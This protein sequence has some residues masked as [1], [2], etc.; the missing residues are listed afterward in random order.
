MAWSGPSGVGRTLL[1]AL[2][3]LSPGLALAG[4]PLL[5]E[6]QARGSVERRFD[7]TVMRARDVHVNMLALRTEANHRLELAL[8]DGVRLEL[9]REQQEPMP[10]GFVWMG[11]VAG[12]ERSLATLSV[13]EDIVSGNITTEDGAVYQLRYAGNGVHSVRQIDHSKFAEEAE[14]IPVEPT[15]DAEDTGLQ[16][17]ADTGSTIDVMVVY[18]AAARSAAGGASAMTSLINLAVSETNTSYSN[19]GITQRIRLVHKAEVSYTETGNI[20]TD[21]GRLRSTTDGY[22]DNVHSLRNTYKAD[23]VSLFVANGGS[24]C[25]IAYLMT[26]VS[27]SFASSGFSVVDKDC[28][29]GY[30]SF[31]HELG[32]NMGARHDR[33]VDNTDGSPYNYNHGHYYTPG[34]WRTVM[35][36]NNG[37]SAVGVSCTRI[38]YWSNPDKFYN[39]VATGV[40]STASNAADNRRT[41]NNTAYTVANFRA[42]Q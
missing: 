34:K 19:S 25:G 5:M 41:L 42:S 8:F 13:V 14:P 2:V 1:T 10:G 32:H 31:G 20:S 9:V 33:Y 29:T 38:A 3:A 18:T 26:S 40:S 22:M 4:S 6:P 36:Y 16:T 11:R 21:L 37:C 7:P 35:A 28:A 39:G 27:T 30:Y 24:Y 15:R 12:Q 23:L 17:M